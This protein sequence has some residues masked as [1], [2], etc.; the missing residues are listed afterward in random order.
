ML[1]KCALPK[2]VAAAATV[3]AAVRSAPERGCA[4][5]HTREWKREEQLLMSSSVV[6]VMV[7]SA[8]W[9]VTVQMCGGNS[10]NRLKFPVKVYQ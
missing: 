3:A 1:D 7:L 2:R 5:C 9:V 10:C 8:G 6:L 4:I